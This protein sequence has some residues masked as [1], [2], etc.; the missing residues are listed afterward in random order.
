[1]IPSEETRK[2]RAKLILEEALETIKALGFEVRLMDALK[3]S[4]YYTVNPK[5]NQIEMANVFNPNLIEIVDGC[6]DISVVTV[7]TLSACGVADCAPLKAVDDSNMKK[8]GPGGYRR[9][10]G[11]WI[12]PP[13]WQA[14][15]LKK[16]L[17]AQGWEEN[18]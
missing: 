1:M 12:K 11:K 18:Q 2:L 16:I 15:D 6:C 14:P 13:D 7:G 9:S 4:L 10:D 5:L 17:L 3:P 8:F